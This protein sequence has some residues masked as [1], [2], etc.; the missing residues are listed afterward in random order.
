VDLG[1]FGDKAD[2]SVTHY[3]QNSSG[4]ILN[5]PVPTSTGYFLQP[6]NAAELQNRGWE[7]TLNLR[8]VTT[9]N[10]AWDVGLQWG[11]NRGLTTA[12]P[13]GLEFVAFPLSGGGNGAGLDVG[14][15][16]QVGQ[17]IGV[18]LG[19]DIV[20]CGRGLISD[21]GVDIDNTAGHC[22]GAP[23]HS[24]YLGPDGRPQFDTSN[25]SYVLGDPNPKWTGSVRTGFRFGKLSIGGLLDVRHGGVA[26]NGTK[27]A[28]NEFGKNQE[29]ATARDNGT[30]VTFGQDY[31]IN[32]VDKDNYVGPGKGVATPLDQSWFQGIA[33]IFNGPNVP[34][35]EDGGFVKLREVSLG[36][37]IDQPWVARTL[38][39][40]SIE[41]RVAGRNIHSWNN[42]TGVD[43]ET[44]LL[45]AA[46]PV[47]GI[48]YFNNPQSRSWVFALTLNR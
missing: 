43:P 23:A 34:F 25:D 41:L 15:S 35:L 12:L 1:L 39:F 45:G 17:P 9:K 31:F 47:R 40:S 18:Y 14:G 7:V 37:T 2:L 48:N 36:Y 4:V 42:Y 38:G 8:P 24:I 10:F 46:S 5:V 32:T 33:S 13:A 3:R 44:A 16:A 30:T 20:R 26:F 6:A 29:T 28:L 22:Q 27:G 11:R 19:S 21:E